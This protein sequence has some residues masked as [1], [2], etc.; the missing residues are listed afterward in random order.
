MDLFSAKIAYAGLDSFLTNVGR[1]IINPLI[2][3]LFALA[4]MY[5]LYGMFEFIAGGDNDEKKTDGK[6]H[7]L[8]GVVGITIMMGVWTILKIVLNTLEIEGIK[9]ETGEVSLPDYNQ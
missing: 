7:M 8:W 3:L 5:F 9:P 6:N 1:E 4:V 2:S